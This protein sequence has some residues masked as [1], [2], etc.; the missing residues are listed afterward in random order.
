MYIVVTLRWLAGWDPVYDWEIIV[1]VGG[2][3]TAPIGFLLGI[4][5]FDYWLY[6]ISGRPTVPDDHANH[7]AYRWQ[8]YFKVNTD[9]KVIGVQYLVTT[10]FFFL[11]GGFLAMLFRAELAQPGMQFFDTQTFNGLVSAH[12]TLMIFVFIIPA[13][14]GLANFAVPLMLGAPDMAFPR[15]NALSFWMLPIAGVM[16]LASFLAPGGAFATGWTSYA[17]LASEQPFGQVFFNMGVQWAGASSIATALNFLVTII[18]MRAPG[19]T[20]WR[21]P[22]LVWANFTTSLLVVIATPFI[23]GSQ[24]FVMFDRVMN[25]SFF[26]PDNGGYV[27]GYQHIFWFYSHPAV[28]IMILPGF[29]IISEIIAVMSRKP[30]FG[31]RLMAISL[32]GILVLG[33]SVWAHHMFVAGMADWLRVPMMISTLLIAV[34]T[35]VKVFS[36]LATLWE[37]K[38]HLNTPMLFAL[39]FVSMFVIGGLS[40]IYLAAVPIDIHASD[41]YFIVAHIHYVLFGGS[42]FTIFAGIYYWFPKMTGRMYNE[43]LGK[44]HFWLTFI[45]FNVTFFPM[46]W[47]GLVGMPRRVADY[48]GDVRRAQHGRHRRLVRARRVGRR[49]RVQHHH[50]LGARADRGLEPVAGAHHRVA[51]HVAAAGLQLRR[52]PT[53][54]GRAI[55]VRRSGRQARGAARRRLAGGTNVNE[56]AEPTVVLVVANETLGGVELLDAV[57]RR[58]E[59][60]PIRAVVIAP[61]NDP[62][63][64]YVVYE[65]S[66]RASAGR[67]VD[68]LVADLRSAGI[69]AY[70]DV[71]EGGPI[72]AVEDILALEPVDELIVSTHPKETSGWL[73]RKNV[74]SELRRLAGDRPFEH[75]VSDVASRTGQANVLVIANETVLG[76]PL[77]DRI[78]RRAAESPAAFLLVCPQSDPDAGEHPDAERR[79]RLALSTLRSEGIEAHGQVAHPDPY[80]AAMNVIEDERVDEVIVSTFPGARSGWLRRDVVERIRKEAGVPVEHVVAD[81]AARAR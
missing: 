28:Y 8:D 30:I 3:V 5:A 52:D 13:F 11:A 51:G 7:G 73:R 50:E 62:R 69:A 60:G 35:G 66:R 10:F 18:T 45:A 29:G 56:V 16:F 54:R 9:H 2:M 64:G 67:R 38:I 6:W 43:R 53:G 40:G 34:P 75:V 33:F 78:R 24:F 71:Y 31:Y 80:T 36:W 58:A 47:V 48:A 72:P 21:M 77:L 44:L 81:L 70:G 26:T 59:R 55:R 4:G 37:G 79:L 42:V 1:L 14:A 63:S 65:N 27:L 41:T 25:T 15:L 23:A 76:T 22:L 39:G 32:L 74:L 46:H 68:R 12:A 57:R 17:P 19:M 49:V 20:F 61:V